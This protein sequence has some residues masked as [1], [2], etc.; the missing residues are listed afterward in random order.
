MAQVSGN[1]GC[2]PSFG[3]FSFGSAHFSSIG[4]ARCEP[5]SARKRIPFAWELG[6]VSRGRPN[7][8]R[9]FFRLFPKIV[10]LLGMDGRQ[11]REHARRRRR[12]SVV[13]ATKFSG[14]STSVVEPRRVLLHSPTENLRR[15]HI[16]DLGHPHRGFA[17]P[18]G[19]GFG[20]N[21]TV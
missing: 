12:A 10:A 1:G 14:Q 3:S 4:I 16:A 9:R 7:R 20:R 18:V 11:I 2:A 5:T 19:L 17:F 6:L 21:V 13:V 8:G 15:T